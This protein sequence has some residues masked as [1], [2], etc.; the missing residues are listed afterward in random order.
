M[1]TGGDSVNGAGAAFDLSPEG[2]GGGDLETGL[3]G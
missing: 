1:T 2:G 3:A